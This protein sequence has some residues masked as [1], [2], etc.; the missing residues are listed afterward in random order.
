MVASRRMAGRGH[1]GGGAHAIGFHLQALNSPQRS[2]PWSEIARPWLAARGDDRAA[3]TFRSTVLGETWQEAG[4]APD[5]QRL[6]DSQEDWPAGGVPAGGLRL[7][8]GVDVQ[9][10]LLEAGLFSA[11]GTG[12]PILEKAPPIPPCGAC[13]V[14]PP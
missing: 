7:T 6:H 4:G 13:T 2:M 1:A 5:R 11:W 10:D 8:A 3:R 9:R 12:S 14:K